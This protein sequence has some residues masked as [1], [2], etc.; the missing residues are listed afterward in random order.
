MAEVAPFCEEVGHDGNGRPHLRLNLHWG[1]AL[2]WESEA[3][4]TWIFA[5]TQAGKTCFEPHWLWREMQARGPGDYLAVTANYDLLALKFEPVLVDLFCAKLKWGVHSPSKRAILGVDG[6][7]RII[8]RSANAFGGLESATA[9][10]ALFDEFGH[11]DFPLEAWEATLRRLSLAQGRILGGSTVYNLG[12]SKQQ[13]H[14]PAVGGDPD[15]RRINFESVMN[16]A[17][18]RAEWERARRTLP[19][20]KFDQ[21][22]RGLYTRPAGLI[23]GDYQDSYREQGGHLVRAFSIP[24]EWP[25]RV[26]VDFGPVHGAQVWLARDPEADCW[27]AYREYLGGALTEPQRA[28][29]ALEYKEP[30]ERWLGGARS[31]GAQ[32]QDWWTAG[33]PVGEPAIADVES[34]I[35]RVT[36]LFRERRL[37]VFDTLTGLRSELGTYSRELDGAGEPLERIADKE[38]FHRLDALRYVA[39]SIPLLTGQAEV[40]HHQPVTTQERAMADLRRALHPRRPGRGQLIR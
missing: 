9:L 17:F 4:F 8:M 14:D 10:A 23:Y 37:F 18:P 33:V 36:G 31:E 5:G 34:G 6:K 30:V 32:R 7:S 25:R 11:K 28:R 1:Q 40:V 29:A 13:L 38:Q 24:P 39:S 22:Y 16:P 3:R 20:W 15:H 2:A 21:M 12:W 35:D 26:G 27:Y 19:A